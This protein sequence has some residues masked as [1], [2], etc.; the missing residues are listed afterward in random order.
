V[1]LLGGAKKIIGREIVHITEPL[2]KVSDLMDLLKKEA[3]DP[4]KLNYD[5]LVIAINGVDCSAIG[6]LDASTGAGDEV[7]VVTVVHGGGATQ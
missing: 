2:I 6:G 3:I 7:T 4:E 1:R 5:N